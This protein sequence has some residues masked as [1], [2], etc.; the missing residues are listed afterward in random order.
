MVFV[1]PQ[2]PYGLDA[3]KPFLSEEQMTF[4]YHKHHAAYFKNLNGLVEGKPEERMTLEELILRATGAVFNN[5][6]QAWNHTFFWHSMAPGGGGEP[7]GALAEALRRDFG[8]VAEF[9][10]A[11]TQAAVRLFGSGWVWL[12]LGSQGKLE[13]VSSGNA[14]NPMTEGKTPLL[15]IDVWEHAYYIDY[16]NERPRFV[17]GFWSVVDWSGAAEK[18]AGAGG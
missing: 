5:A 9:R 8:G 6:A 3:L 18:L 4:H 11:F 7:G 15:C 16:R 17:E 2:L 14:G 10:Q 13:I 1:Q 12:A